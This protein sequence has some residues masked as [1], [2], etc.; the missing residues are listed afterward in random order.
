MPNIEI[1]ARCLDSAAAKQIAA[2]LKA[3]HV[4]TDH[5]TDTYFKTHAGRLKLR[6]SSLSEAQLIPYIRPS[7]AGPKKSEYTLLSVP[8]PELCKTLLDEILGIETVVDKIRE[9][10]LIGNVRVHI[11]CVHELG[12]FI[13]FEAV[14]TDA[15]DETSE[16]AKIDALMKEFNITSA[17]LLTGSY[18]ELNLL[19][20]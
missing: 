2:R 13:E 15:Q 4:G 11:D 19:G 6:E 16:R 8:N 5:Q 1:K 7:Q 17:D 10:Y 14:Y 3:K 20:R 12:N 9:I 18:R